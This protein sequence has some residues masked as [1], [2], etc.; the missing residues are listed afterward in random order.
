MKIGIFQN[1]YTETQKALLDRSFLP[2]DGTNH[3][4]LQ[5]YEMYWIRQLYEWKIYQN[6]DYCGLVS[7]KFGQKTR[8][9]GSK[10]LEFMHEN[11][12]YDVY[13][14]NPFPQLPYLF[15]N[16]WDCGEYYHPGLATKAQQ[17]LNAVG[18]SYILEDSVRNSPKT[19]LYCNYWVASPP[20]WEEYFSFLRPMLDHVTEE[21][22]SGN[23]DYTQLTNHGS[24]LYPYLPFIFERF[25]SFYLSNLRTDKR[26]IAYKYSPSELESNCGP[27]DLQIM[28]LFGSLIDDFDQ[29]PGSEK[30]ESEKLIFPV[31]RDLRQHFMHDIE[32]ISEKDIRI[33]QLETELSMI[34]NSKTWRIMSA[35]PNFWSRLLA[36]GLWK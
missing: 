5:F 36:G 30:Y 31:L 25:F 7:W 15:F 17:L 16:V 4:Q 2:H 12:G 24:G 21:M 29:R 10:F 18:H 32:S 6:Y 20:F 8:I 28:K 23:S 22:G 13:F 11:P 35:W 14:I 19:L 26:F 33:H 3:P 1:Y 27:A 34:R 9:P